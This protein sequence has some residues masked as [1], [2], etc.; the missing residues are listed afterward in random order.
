MSTAI[1]TN[2]LIGLWNPDDAL[3]A[4]S[5][6][7]LDAALRRGGLVI[8]APVFAELAAYPGRSESSVDAFCK[9]TGIVVDW[10]LEE[11]IWRSAARAFR[12]YADRRAK[13]SGSRPRRLL[14]DFLIG[15]HA[16]CRGYPL[17]TLDDRLY[18]AAFPQLRIVAA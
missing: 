3:S 5:Q 14:T 1:D 7:A 12:S 15:A 8:S 17:L 2:I 9:E 4:Q 10:A 6:S 16:Q 11:A 13:R 18:S